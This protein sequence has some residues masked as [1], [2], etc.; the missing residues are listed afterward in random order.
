MAY[1]IDGLDARIKIDPFCS[2]QVTRLICPK[3]T[4]APTFLTRFV[5]RRLITAAELS[6][7]ERSEVKCTV[8][9]RLTKGHWA[10][11]AEFPIGTFQTIW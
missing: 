5:I 9:R 7:L 1:I 2:L 3:E 11:L 8:L 6:E 10:A 4:Y